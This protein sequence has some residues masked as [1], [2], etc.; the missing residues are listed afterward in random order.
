MDMAITIRNMSTR[1]KSKS[2]LLLALN[3]LLI[4]FIENLLFKTMKD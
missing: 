2:F 4:K 1:G 3:A